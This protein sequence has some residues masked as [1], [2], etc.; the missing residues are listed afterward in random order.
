MRFPFRGEV[1]QKEG[2]FRVKRVINRK[3]YELDF[4][5]GGAYAGIHPV[6]NVER[7]EEYV[8]PAQAAFPERTVRTP[9]PVIVRNSE[10]H[11]P[12]ERFVKHRWRRGKL[13]FLVKW[14]GYNI[15]DNT[16]EPAANLKADMKERYEEAKQKYEALK[17]KIE[18]APAPAPKPRAPL[19]P[20]TSGPRQAVAA[21][22][23]T[24]AAGLRPSR[25]K[26]LPQKLR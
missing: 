12:I 8:E 18:P 4:P 13:Q 23:P 10:T 15:S 7:L 9:A 1:G 14:Q 19:P 20:E 17:G 22:P 24:A 3:A 21:P 26:T 11:F 5:P 25:A 6:I 16:W 2:P